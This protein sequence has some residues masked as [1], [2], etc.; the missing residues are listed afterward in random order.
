MEEEY[1]S[2]PACKRFYREYGGFTICVNIGEKG[3]VLA[4]HYNKRFTAFYYLIYGSGRVGKLFDPNYLPMEQKTIVDVQDYFYDE[5]AFQ[6]LEDFHL[7]GFNIYHKHIPWEY[8]LLTPDDRSVVMNKEK[9]HLICLNGKVNVSGTSLK[10][11]DHLKLEKDVEY[12]LDNPD[13]AEICIF[14]ET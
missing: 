5:L 9:N 6:A 13:G 8:K 4:E 7:I 12:I 11:Y 3:Y 2:D 10:R 1:K 14:S